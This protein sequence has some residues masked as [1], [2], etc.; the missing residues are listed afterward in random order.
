MRS[1]AKRYRVSPEEREKILVRVL[2]TTKREKIP[3]RYACIREGQPF[4]TVAQWF[5]LHPDLEEERSKLPYMRLSPEQRKEF[6]EAANT[7][8]SKN[9]I[10]LEAISE[11]Q[12]FLEQR[13]AELEEKL[14]E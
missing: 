9:A 12:D 1:K 8:R 11:R 5:R 13:I 3:L 10:Y 4:S 2:E 6:G 7:F 14:E